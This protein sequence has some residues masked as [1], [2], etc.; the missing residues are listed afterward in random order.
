[1]A[2]GSL[3]EEP[4]AVVAPAS[5]VRRVLA[6]APPWT[7]VGVVWI[8]LVIGLALTQDAFFTYT[9]LT[10]ILRN[11]SVPLLMATG[12][13]FVLITGMIDL[14]IGSMLGLCAVIMFG[15][16]KLG[17]PVVVVIPLTIVA[18]A[19][20]GGGFNGV[21]ISKFDLS[22]FVVGL[23]STSLFL[24]AAQLPTDGQPADLSSRAGFDVINTIGDGSIQGF[25]VPGIIA[26]CG[27]VVGGL[28]LRYLNLGRALFA[29]GGNEKAA[30]LVGIPV[31]RTRIIAFAMG[32]AFVGI[33]ALVLAGR[34]FSADPQG[35]IGT[36]LTAIAA[37]LLGGT[38]FLGGSGTM[39]GTLVAVLFV[40]TLQ[41]GLTLIG[42][43]QFWQGAVTGAVL[44]I[45][46]A[47][48]R[49][50]QR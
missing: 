30:N 43:Q 23:G 44:I 48:D 14:S 13:T 50:R 26:L 4:P 24:A 42:V 40:G 22:F 38:S 29:V 21:L 1:M 15:L 8:G 12:A 46:V 6:G 39:V 36:E 34:T 7:G 9:N 31:V 20:L 41:N 28:V 25:P 5:R 37:V 27:I 10:D 49:L 3:A 18:G 16:M 19:L 35:G 45:A 47:L 2:E 33:A 17:I 32:G 11:N